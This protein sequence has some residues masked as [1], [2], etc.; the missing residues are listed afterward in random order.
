MCKNSLKLSY[1]ILALKNACSW[2]L[3]TD[4]ISSNENNDGVKVKQVN[5]N[6]NLLV[7]DIIMEVNREKV[8]TLS[9]FEDYVL[10]I[11]ESGLTIT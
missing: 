6:S 5:E 9:Q 3:K 10:K 7:G 4:K 11:N 2:P 8:S 1:S